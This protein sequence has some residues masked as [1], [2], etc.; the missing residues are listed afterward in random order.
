[1]RN[2]LDTLGIHPHSEYTLRGDPPLP[3]TQPSK[4]CGCL[5]FAV[6]WLLSFG[7]VILVLMLTGCKAKSIPVIQIRD[8][9]RTKT[10]TNT[11]I[12]NDTQYVTLPPQTV[13]RITPD[14]TS[15]LHT[16]YATSSALIRGGILYHKLTT[17]ETPLPVPVQHKETTRDSIVYREREVPV[18]VP[19]IQE[20]EKPLN[21]WQSARIHFANIVMIALG[22]LF[23]V[24]LIRK[25]SWWM[26]FLKR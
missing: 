7:L 16:D 12:V 8:S 21:P 24:W 22:V 26:K 20:V 1:M 18:P 14:T 2:H 6:C 11:V 15:I 5:V 23:A 10:V 17:N 25:R 4:P 13:E 9:I 19:V 3:G